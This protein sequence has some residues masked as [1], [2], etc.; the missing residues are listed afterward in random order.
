MLS[1]IAANL[2][3]IA[4][5]LPVIFAI[6]LVAHDTMT[7]TA[8][9]KKRRNA[10]LRADIKKGLRKTSVLGGDSGGI[11]THNLLIRSQM[12]YSV[13][14]RNHSVLCFL[15]SRLTLFLNCECKGTEFFLYRQTFPQLFFKKLHFSCFRP[16]FTPYLAI[17]TARA[18]SAERNL[19]SPH[20]NCTQ[21]P[22]TTICA[23]VTTANLKK[24]VVSTT[25]T[26][27]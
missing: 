7:T 22:E 14:L 1:I 26:T 18:M 13:E 24:R 10:A 27:L 5:T 20:R 4:N 21:R 23:L 8:T 19:A 3:I 6:S 16:Y 17:M 9:T 2:H 11:Q 12:L 15:S 25:D